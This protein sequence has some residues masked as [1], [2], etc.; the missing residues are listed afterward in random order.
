MAKVLAVTSGKGGV[1]KSTLCVGM[2]MCFAAQ[3][4]Q[5]LLLELDAGLRGVDLM[6][7]ISDRIV[8]DLGDLLE[9][10][11]NINRALIPSPFFE[12]LS[13]IAA[14]TSS[15][16]MLPEDLL[17]LIRGL[18][19]YF[20]KVILDMP[21]GLGLS[22]ALIPELAD[23]AL[24][25]AT[26]DAVSIRD[27]RQV[28]ENLRRRQFNRHRL[29]INRVSHRMLKKQVI[30]DLDEVID[31]VGSQLIGAVPEDEMLALCTLKGERLPE[32]VPIMRIFSA[33]ARRI[34]GQY[35]PLLLHE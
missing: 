26:P 29:I 21:A 7:G 33:I 22:I 20:D 12:N 9:G 5:V 4:Q 30:A 6:L 32:D 35:L 18:S 16:P 24:I 27:G 28:V 2:S 3:G 19:P 1:G 23:L 11:C 13:V 15:V 8:Y 10:R 17:L 34:D 25:V 31:G 14:S